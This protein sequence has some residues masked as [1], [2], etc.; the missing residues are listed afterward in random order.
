MRPYFFAVF[1][2]FLWVV[3]TLVHA[4]AASSDVLKDGAY[5]YFSVKRLGK[6]LMDTDI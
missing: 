2:G 1:D 3:C 5:Q 6:K 4:Y